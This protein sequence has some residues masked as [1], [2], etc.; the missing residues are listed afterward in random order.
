MNGQ[1]VQCPFTRRFQQNIWLCGRLRDRN[2]KSSEYN[3]T[4][5]MLPRQE[6]VDFAGHD[7]WR[8][9]AVKSQMEMR[10]RKFVLL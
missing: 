3:L 2:R 5:G 1:G 8:R 6:L 4:T 7:A 10:S 9:Q